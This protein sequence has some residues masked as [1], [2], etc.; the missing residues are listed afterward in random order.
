MGAEGGEWMAVRAE[1]LRPGFRGA[2][3]M[4]TAVRLTAGAGAGAAATCAGFTRSAILPAL[5][6]VATGLA[7]AL[8]AGFDTDFDSIFKGGAGALARADTGFPGDLSRLATSGA[9]LCA[10]TFAAG[11]AVTTADFLATALPALTAFLAAAAGADLTTALAGV[12]VFFAWAFTMS[13]LWEAAW[14]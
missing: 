13:L 7:I 6:S 8:A 9:F 10:A 2:E 4:R 3:A 5:L 1:L 11:F 12:M 14:G